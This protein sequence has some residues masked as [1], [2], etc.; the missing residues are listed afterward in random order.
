MFEPV[1]EKGD[2]EGEDEGGGPGG[3]GV[4]L[5]ADLSVA[6]CFDDAGSEEGV[7]VGG[8]DEAEV[9]ESAED[10]FEVFEAVEDVGEG[11]SAVA[12]GAALVFEEAGA[13]VGSFVFAE[14]VGLGVSRGW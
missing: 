5:G 1:G 13:D 6:V 4:E 3:N 12:G 8:D 2:D 14:P 7:A 9:H 11:Y 10:E